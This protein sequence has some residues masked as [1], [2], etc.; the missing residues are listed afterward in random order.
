MS[1]PLVTR[2]SRD[3]DD[4][5]P[6][7]RTPTVAIMFNE[8]SGPEQVAGLIMARHAFCEFEVWASHDEHQRD[9]WVLVVWCETATANELVDLIGSRLPDYIQARRFPL[10]RYAHVRAHGTQIV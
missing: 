6:A 4:G 9:A 7:G 2:I 8:K 10:S 3:D 1:V 5:T